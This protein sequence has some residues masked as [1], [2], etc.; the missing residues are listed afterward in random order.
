MQSHLLRRLATLCHHPM[1]ISLGQG[2]GGLCGTLSQ[3]LGSLD[4]TVPISKR[5]VIISSKPHIIGEEKAM[6]MD[7]LESLMLLWCCDRNQLPEQ[8]LSLHSMSAGC[9]GFPIVRPHRDA[10]GKVALWSPFINEDTETHRELNSLVTQPVGGGAR[11]TS[12]IL[13]MPKPCP[14]LRILEQGKHV[15]NTHQCFKWVDL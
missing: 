10:I 6:H 2:F 3:P 14:Y 4:F 5:R 9:M 12:K 11:V 7:V 13:P 15:L 8:G 1:E